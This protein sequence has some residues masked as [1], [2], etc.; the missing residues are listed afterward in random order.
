MH[1]YIHTRI[2]L[3]AD[4]VDTRALP[5]QTT[6]DIEHQALMLQRKLRKE[7]CMYASTSMYV[8]HAMLA[9]VH[10]TYYLGNDR[11]GHSSNKK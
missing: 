3:M 5:G 9:Y 10:C 4:Y 8:Q 7:V 6:G 2:H 1:A 11:T